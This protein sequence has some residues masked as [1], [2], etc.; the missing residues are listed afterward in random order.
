MPSIQAVQMIIDQT[1]GKPRPLNLKIAAGIQE[2]SLGAS[3]PLPTGAAT[4]SKQDDNIV[5][6]T[7]I[8]T[9]LG[10]TLTVD[11]SAVTQPI[12]ATSLPLPTGAAS[13]VT[14]ASIDTALAGTLAV[15]F[16]LTKAT[17][18]LSNSQS[19]IAGDFST[20]SQDCTNLNKVAIAGTFTGSAEIEIWISHDDTTFYKWGQNSLFPNNGVVGAAFDAPFS[21]YKLKYTDTGTATVN[22]FASN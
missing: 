16:S 13:E 10:G 3:L 1:T 19:V 11:G 22:G 9:A 2:V 21:Y 12:S 18:A 14:L 8:N 4:E 20:S 7:A 17:K 5:Q 15:S 6:T